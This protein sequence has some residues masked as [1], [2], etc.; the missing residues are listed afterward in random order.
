[1]VAKLP[2]NHVTMLLNCMIEEADTLE[3]VRRGEES[4]YD[5]DKPRRT[6][7]PKNPNA[8]DISSMPIDQLHGFL[9]DNFG[10]SQGT[11]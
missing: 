9:A 4:T 7:K 11:G 1:M 3:A 6:F 8:V 2:L 5:A 10:T